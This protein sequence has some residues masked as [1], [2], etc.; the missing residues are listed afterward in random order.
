METP[1]LA[2]FDTSPHLVHHVFGGWMPLSWRTCSRFCVI[3]KTWVRDATALIIIFDT[4]LIPLLHQEKLAVE[5]KALF[6]R[7]P[8]DEAVEK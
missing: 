5:G 2:D 8:G 4:I 6:V 3:K 1:E 7:A